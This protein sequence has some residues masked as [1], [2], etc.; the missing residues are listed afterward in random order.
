M[1]QSWLVIIQSAPRF[2]PVFATGPS[3]STSYWTCGS[4]LRRSQWYLLVAALWHSSIAHNVLSWWGSFQ[5]LHKGVSFFGKIETLVPGSLQVPW[6]MASVDCMSVECGSLS[7]FFWWLWC[8]AQVYT[9]DGVTFKHT[10]RYV[11]MPKYWY[12]WTFKHE[13]NENPCSSWLTELFQVNQSQKQILL[14]IA[15]ESTVALDSFSITT[16]Y[17]T[18][19]KL[20][21]ILTNILYIID[22]RIAL[23]WNSNFKL[24]HSTNILSLWVAGTWGIN[25][26]DLNY[27]PQS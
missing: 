10:K 1:V 18:S 14:L 21:S 5:E 2:F 9:H 25:T 12:T 20:L 3:N 26:H 4:G 17:T 15:L 13:H 27:I 7:G 6:T 16:C 22:I 11:L 19:K 24:L 8:D 23:N